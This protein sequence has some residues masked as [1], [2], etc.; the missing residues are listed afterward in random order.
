MRP[1][2]PLLALAVAAGFGAL[3]CSATVSASAAGDAEPRLTT[4]AVVVV[5]R[6]VDPAGSPRAEVSARFVRVASP[7]STEDAVKAIGAALVLPPA[8]HCVPLASLSGSSML[9]EPAPVVE[10]VD[11]GS[12]VLDADGR[13]TRLVSRMLPDVTDVV[14]GMV[15]A[16]TADPALLPAEGR[17]TLRVG[18]RSDLAAFEIVS[19]APADPSNVVTSAPEVNG[20]LEVAGASLSFSWPSG[21][22]GDVVYVDVQPGAIRCVL[23]DESPAGDPLS[24]SSIP[25]ALLGD[26]GTLVVHRL[27]SEPLVAQGIEGGELRFDFGRSVTYVRTVRR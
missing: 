12:V 16:R 9:A 27:R 8:G 11:V 3:G 21:T 19:T 6:L 14:S 2:A 23:G 15:Y 26:S 24:R 20:T 22:E 1:F 5:E 17:Y 10:L 18:G 4:S 13:E 25:T 7:V